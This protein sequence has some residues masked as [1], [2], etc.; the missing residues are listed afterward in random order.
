MQAHD[1][2]LGMVIN[3]DMTE[4]RIVRHVDLNPSTHIRTGLVDV[5][6]EYLVAPGDKYL[7]V[8]A[9]SSWHVVQPWENAIFVDESGM[10]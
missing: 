9:D 8:P 6:N 4:Y 5:G 2:Q 7:V 1:L 10:Y 3:T